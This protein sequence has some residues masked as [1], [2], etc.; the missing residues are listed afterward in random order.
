MGKYVVTAPCLELAFGASSPAPFSSPEFG[1]FAPT[2]IET[3]R[4]PACGPGS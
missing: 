2:L 3:G 4:E 1:E